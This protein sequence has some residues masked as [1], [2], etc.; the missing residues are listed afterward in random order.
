VVI[1]HR[2]YGYIGHD[3]RMAID[4]RFRHAQEF[5]EGLALVRTEGKFVPPFAMFLGTQ[6]D[7]SREFKYIDKSGRVRIRFKA[8]QA[9]GFSEGLAEFAVVKKDGYLYCGYRD[10]M[11][12]EVIEPKFGGCDDFSEGLAS[13]LLDGKWHFIDRMGRFVI[14]PPFVQVRSFHNGLAFV[15]DGPTPSS[16]ADSRYIDK[17]GKVV[18]KPQH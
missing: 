7:Q 18:W 9:S 17:T 10:K 15:L 3:G 2:K 1:I 13:V 6:A 4:A 14:D 12:K 5:S 11:G 16:A 8:E